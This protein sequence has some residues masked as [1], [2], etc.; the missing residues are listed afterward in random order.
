MP[1][2][3]PSTK[4]A[5]KT[6]KKAANKVV[7]TSA[8]KVSKKAAKKATKKTSKKVAKH[9]RKSQTKVVEV[10]AELRHQMIEQAAYYRAEER[11]FQDGDPVADWLICEKEINALLSNGGH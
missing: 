4:S 8:K 11:G 2:K 3:R 1:A 10:S 7:R 5:K 6:T 9:P